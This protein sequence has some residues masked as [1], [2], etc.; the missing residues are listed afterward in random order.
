M[1]LCGIY[2]GTH[3]RRTG[4]ITQKLSKERAR[5]RILEAAKT[6]FAEAG[7]EAAST[8]RIAESAGVAQSLLLYHFASK[9]ELWRAVVD[10]VFAQAERGLTDVA[11]RM[12]D[13]A[14]YETRLMNPIRSLVDTFAADADLHRIILHEGKHES[15]RLTWLVETHLRRLYE[16]SIALLKEGQAAGLVRPGDPTLLHYSIVSIAGTVFSLS[17]EIRKLDPHTKAN[18]PDAVTA[19]IRDVL[20]I[21]PRQS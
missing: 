1:N 18:D 6:R 11:D 21:A 7:F 8:R 9:E 13:D 4:A 17:P 15:E 14:D 3:A 12:P 20:M 5:E 16:N 10:G 2:R 19:L